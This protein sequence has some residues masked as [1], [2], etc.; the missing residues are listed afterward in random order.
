MLPRCQ[1]ELSTFGMGRVRGCVG[2]PWH[3]GTGTEGKGQQR[4]APGKGCSSSLSEFL[5]GGISWLLEEDVSSQGLGQAETLMKWT[6]CHCSD[7][8]FLYHM[9]SLPPIKCQHLG[10]EWC[11]FSQLL[12]SASD[13][14]IRFVL[15]VFLEFLNYA[16]NFFFLSLL[17][18]L[19]LNFTNLLYFLNI[20]FLLYV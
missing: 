9:Q 1:K 7:W 12:P 4:K 5:Y 8:L 16:S 18:E 14:F 19:S 6:N 20:F 13:F 11:R 15:P 3:S 10:K 17:R 2:H